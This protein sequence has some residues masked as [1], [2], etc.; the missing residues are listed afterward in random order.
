MRPSARLETMAK[1]RIPITA[2]TGNPSRSLVTTSTEL[3]WLE[4]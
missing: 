4:D 3:P 2:P 1:R